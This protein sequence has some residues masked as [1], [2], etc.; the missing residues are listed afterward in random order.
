MME[1]ARMDMSSPTGSIHG[2]SQPHP[3]STGLAAALRSSAR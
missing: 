3:P 1:N 2:L